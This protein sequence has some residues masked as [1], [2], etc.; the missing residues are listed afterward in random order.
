MS[1]SNKEIAALI[2]DFLSSSSSSVNEDYVDSLNVAIDCITEAFQF[3]RD[4]TDSLISGPFNGKKLPELLASAPS[5]GGVSGEPVKVHIPV[6]DAAAKAKAEELK[7]QGNK[8]M[9][10]KKFDEAIEKYTAAIEVSPSNAVY[11][12]NRAAAYSSLK[13]YEQAVKDA[14]QAIEVDPTYSKGF[15]RLGFAKYA[16]NKPEEALDAYKKVLDI[17]GEKATDVMKRDYETAKKKVETSMNLEKSSTSASSEDVS[18]K[19]ATEGP[20]AG[21]G[22][23]PDLSSLLGGGGLGGGLGAL[24]NNP[25]VMQAAEKMMQNPG[26]MQDMMSNPA[27]K[28]MANQFSSGGGMPDL[29][30]MMNDPSIR[31]MAKNMFGGGNGSQQ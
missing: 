4:E 7:L 22:G 2:V 3:E 15:S 26:L 30:Q 20:G 24:L 9:A 23:L 10:A 27:M 11:Y 12:S 1:L 25:Q 16:L 5:S 28:Q 14:E 21:A 31:D 18:D 13:Q 8:A 29:S 6:E 19:S 17:E